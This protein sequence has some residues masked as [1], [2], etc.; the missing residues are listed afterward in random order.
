MS[1]F[2]T[3]KCILTHLER[4]V[5]CLENIQDICVK[6]ADEYDNETMGK[7]STDETVSVYCE[8]TY[9][10]AGDMIRLLESEIDRIG[11]LIA[12]VRK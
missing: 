4:S 7:S 5:V 3:R 12:G 11:D 1:N 8:N 9:K 6:I 10:I 2:T